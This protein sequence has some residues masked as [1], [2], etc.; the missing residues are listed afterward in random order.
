MLDL[1]N[2]LQLFSS[3]RLNILQALLNCDDYLC[4][5]NLINELDIPKNLLSYHIKTLI[6]LGYIKEVKCGRNKRYSIR[7]ESE[8]KVKQI[9]NLLKII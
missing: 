8:D 4:G 7:P 6:D 3:A 9:F 5:C 2:K 1:T